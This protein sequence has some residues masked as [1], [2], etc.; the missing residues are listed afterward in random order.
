MY[1]FILG[2]TLPYPPQIL[3]ANW[4]S[5]GISV[6]SLPWIAHKICILK[7]VNNI[8]LCCLLQ[9]EEGNCLKPKI[10]SHLLGDHPNPPHKWEL[11][12]KE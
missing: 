11:R 5:F 10:S 8:C 3:H 12:N 7:E 9:G 2:D 6:M 4:L 1:F